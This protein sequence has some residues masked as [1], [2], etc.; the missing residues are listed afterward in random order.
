MTSEELKL[1]LIMAV[2]IGVVLFGIVAGVSAFFFS[3]LALGV[4]PF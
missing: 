1:S 3:G 2:V 4:T